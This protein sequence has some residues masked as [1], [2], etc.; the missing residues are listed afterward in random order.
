MQKGLIRDFWYRHMGFELLLTKNTSL[1]DDIPE[2]YYQKVKDELMQ[3][4]ESDS[5]YIV[6]QAMASELN[7]R[8]KTVA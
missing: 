7:E 1:M 5:I 3:D 2:D 6:G 4:L 8:K